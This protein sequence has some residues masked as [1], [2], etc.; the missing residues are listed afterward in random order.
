MPGGAPLDAG[1]LGLLRSLVQAA[2]VPGREDA[3]RSLI[4][5]RAQAL[6][7]FD[8]LRTDTLGSLIGIRK[9][10][11]GGGSAPVRVLLS[12]HMDQVGFLVSHVSQD[13]HLR[14]HPVGDFDPRGLVSC[15]LRIHTEGGV[16]TGVLMPEGHPVHTGKPEDRTKT[17]P[18]PEFYVDLGSAA[19]A[20]PVQLGDMAVFDS[21]FADLGDCVMGPALDNRIGCWALL[22]ALAALDRHDCEITAVWSAQEELG[23]RGME[24]VARTMPADIGISCDTVVACDVP[25][26]PE[27]QSVCRL[28]GG[29]A[30]VVADSS[31]LSDMTVLRAVE[32]VARAA[33]IPVQRCLMEGGGQDGALIQRARDGVRTLV[34]SCPVRH[35]HS[36]NE[37]AA[38]S[39][40]AAYAALLTAYL[41]RV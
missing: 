17:P 33:R 12:A 2:G 5:S 26:I 1:Q 13:G 24:P 31:T 20:G 40:I 29:M 32:G 10:R 14:L 11:G 38:K 22:E 35:M 19:Q 23:S 36:A 3:V 28:G 39:D 7:L 8:E 4:R 18:L 15:R 9:P 16:L 37:I 41:S 25:G 6:S 30:L 34:L 21:P 27:A